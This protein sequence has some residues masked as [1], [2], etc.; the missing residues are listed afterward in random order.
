MAQYNA[1]LRNV[2]QF[3]SLSGDIGFYRDYVFIITGVGAY[4]ADENRPARI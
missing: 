1:I 2:H 4:G 3:L